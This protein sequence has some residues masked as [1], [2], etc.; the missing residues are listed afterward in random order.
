MMMST[1][2][3][4]PEHP[5]AQRYDLANPEVNFGRR[6]FLG[7]VVGLGATLWALLIGGT[8]LLSYLWPKKTEEVA[9]KELKFEKK[10]TEFPPG[11]SKN[12]MYGS[13]PALLINVG[14]TLSVFN[15]KCT[16]LG[17]TVQYQEE[18]KKIYCAC[19]GGT[20]DPQT[21]K[22]IAGPPPAPL[23]PLK[24]EVQDDG[25]ILIKKA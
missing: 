22:N 21:G 20:Y 19:H 5:D 6:A 17:C 16:H 23:T 7:G 12:F 25:T 13:M 8:P 15:A 3:H 2:H 24:A 11:S 18:K 14:G 9:I 1:E 4:S 10:I